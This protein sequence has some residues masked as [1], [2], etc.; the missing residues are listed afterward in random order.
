[1]NGEIT[2][3][4]TKDG[5]TDGKIDPKT[6][7]SIPFDPLNPDESDWELPADVEPLINVITFG[8]TEDGR[9]GYPTDKKCGM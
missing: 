2:T 3:R 8:W 7:E 1:M 6:G 5:K 4:S 9:C